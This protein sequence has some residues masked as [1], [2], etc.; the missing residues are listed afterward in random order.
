MR[1]SHPFDR[2]RYS[3]VRRRIVRT[4]LAPV[5]RASDARLRETRNLSGR[6]VRR[7]LICRPNHRL[8]NLLLLT[9]LLAELERVFPEATVDL[10]LAGDDGAGLFAAFGN[11]RH[12]YALS[13]RMVRH[14]LALLRTALQIRRAGYDLAID[15]CE[16]SQSGRLVVAVAN[17]K[18]VVGLPR[19]R[20]SAD[21]DDSAALLAAPRHMAQWP[22]YLLRH[23][24]ARR[25]PDA[26]RDFPVPDIR[27][28]ADER[29]LASAALDELLRADGQPHAGM[30][31]GV[32]AEATGGKRYPRGWWQRFI[33]AVRRAH[34]DCAF[35]EILPPDGR[36]R[37]ALGLPTFCS[38]SPRKVAAMIS[39][40]TCFVSADCGVMHL[41][42]ASGTPTLGLFSVTDVS[43]YEPYGRGSRAFVTNGKSPEE[44]AQ[45][46]SAHVESLL[47]ADCRAGESPAPQGGA[48]ARQAG[49]HPGPADGDREFRRAFPYP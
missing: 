37:L 43:K 49:P 12:V 6:D 22:V 23:A 19:N 25:L 34:P 24:L 42:S 40:M 48:K 7:I 38:Q 4:A 47:A 28:S 41:A 9:P 15:P 30:V 2:R 3:E 8:G 16:A 10:V 5:F 11:V 35:V 27:L 33:G 18:Y 32:F 45:L 46:A 26:D 29:R 31:V 17:A 20:K 1:G 39:D 21:A 13:R 44:V 14:P 36:P